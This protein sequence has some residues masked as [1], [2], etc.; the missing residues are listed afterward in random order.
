MASSFELCTPEGRQAFFDQIEEDSEYL[1]QTLTRQQ[2]KRIRYVLEIGH[3]VKGLTKAGKKRSEI[4]YRSFIDEKS[5][6]RFLGLKTFANGLISGG[7]DKFTM[8]P[9]WSRD[10]LCKYDKRASIILIE[11]HARRLNKVTTLKT[12]RIE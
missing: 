11:P 3:N 1:Y 7:K 10:G 6:E 4:G 9:D 12:Y 5:L 8:V 2:F